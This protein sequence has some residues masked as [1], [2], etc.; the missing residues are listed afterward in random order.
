M[1]IFQK[2]QPHREFA[3][4][5]GKKSLLFMTALALVMFT[6]QASAQSVTLTSSNSATVSGS[7]TEIMVDVSQTGVTDSGNAIEVV[8]DIDTNLV[9]LTGGPAGW[10]IRQGNT[11]SLLSIG[12]MASLPAS[13]SF[14]FT[15]ATDVTDMEFSIGISEI[16]LDGNALAGVPLPSAL[17]FNSQ[18]ANP[19]FDGDGT[20]GVSDFLLFVNH[21]GTSRGDAGYDAKYDLD[22]NDVIGV[23]DFLIFVNSFGKKVPTS[24]GGGGGGSGSPDLIV[25]SPSVSDSTLTTGQSFTLSATVRNQGNGQAAATTLRYYRSSNSTISTSDTEVGKDSVSGLSVSGTSAES[26]SLTAPSSA[27]TYYYGACVNSVTRESD[28][29][30]NCSDAVTVTVS[31]SGGGGGGGGGS[32][33]TYSVGESLPNF[34]SGFFVP[35]Q[36]SKASFQFS[37]GRAVLGF[38]NGGLIK[39][40][41]GTTYTCIASG[42]CGVEGGRVTAG[43]IGVTTGSSGGGSGGSGGSPDLVVE[44]PSVDNSSPDAGESFTLSATVRNQGNGQAAATTL[45]YYRSSDATISTSDTEVGKDSVGGLSASGTSAESVSLTAPSSAGTYY[46]GACVESVTGESDTNNNCS[47]G[48]RVTVSSSSSGGSGGS[49]GACRAGLVVNPSESCTYKSHTFS[50]SSSG[51]GSIAFFSAGTGIDTRGSTVNGVRWDFHA[52]KNSGSNSWTIHTA[53]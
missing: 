8:F 39:L 27:G 14:T 11:A 45:R 47:D 42:G 12:G 43:T 46:Y 37:Q 34:P 20:V 41:D 21:F 29:G 3:Y 44:S 52:T 7:G 4:V 9:T 32:S 13:A 48:V 38:Q 51:R 10:L 49:H 35:A 31:S 5:Y 22:S 6:G 1:L 30:N 23:S 15:T 28:T 50:V 53:D 33:N 40:Q 19:D 25:T 24:G 36:V 2:P 26:I 16:S 18:Y 17:I